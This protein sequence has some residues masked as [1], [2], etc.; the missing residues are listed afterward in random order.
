MVDAW[1][2]QLP[3]G[4]NSYYT[5]NFAPENGGVITGRKDSS[6]IVHTKAVHAHMNRQQVEA[7]FTGNF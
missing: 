7:E 2:G 3:G 5:S 4:D 6:N 1:T